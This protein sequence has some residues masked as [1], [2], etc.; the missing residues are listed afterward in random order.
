MKWFHHSLNSYVLLWRK[1]SVLWRCVFYERSSGIFTCVLLNCLGNGWEVAL[2]SLTWQN[3]FFFFC[4]YLCI[5][6]ANFGSF[7]IVAI[8]CSQSGLLKKKKT[9]VNDFFNESDLF[10]PK[11]HTALMRSCEV[12][13]FA[14]KRKTWQLQKV[15]FTR[16][17]INGYGMYTYAEIQDGYGM[18]TFFV[19]SF[20]F[21]LM[22]WT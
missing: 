6:I 8:A 21:F 16:G 9:K 3:I 4:F 19:F 15:S 20:L 13:Q 22:V 10:F 1:C 18:D 17:E 14:G 2:L 7:W 5:W 12:C 11:D